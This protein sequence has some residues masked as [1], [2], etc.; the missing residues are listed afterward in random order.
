MDARC[1]PLFLLLVARTVCHCFFWPALSHISSCGCYDFLYSYSGHL[2]AMQANLDASCF[3][4]TCA[5]STWYA[6]PTFLMKVSA[7]P[8]VEISAPC[9][10]LLIAQVAG[11]AS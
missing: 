6:P 11:A 10:A 4:L 3:A 7:S 1:S 9:L 2:R 5:Y 8:R